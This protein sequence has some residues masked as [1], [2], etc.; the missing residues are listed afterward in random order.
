SLEDLIYRSLNPGKEPPARDPRLETIIMLAILKNI[1]VAEGQTF[2]QALDAQLDAAH[3]V[4][5]WI[6]S[7]KLNPNALLN[8]SRQR[9]AIVRALARAGETVP[10]QDAAEYTKGFL[11]SFGMD[12]AATA[13]D[14]LGAIGDMETA[15]RFLTERADVNL[16]T[17]IRNLPE[18]TRDLR[19]LLGYPRTEPDET[20]EMLFMG[21]LMATAREARENGTDFGAT[22]T[23]K[24]DALGRARSY[25]TNIRNPEDR[26][27][28][29]RSLR[30]SMDDR[31]AIFG[32]F[33]KALGEKM[34]GLAYDSRHP[35]ANAISFLVYFA[36]HGRGIRDVRL[37]IAKVGRVREMVAKAS[38]AELQRIAGVPAI[39]QDLARL[40]GRTF[41]GDEFSVIL[42]F[43]VNVPQEMRDAGKIAAMVE[44]AAAK[45]AK[46][47]PDE[48]QSVSAFYEDLLKLLEPAADERRVNDFVLSAVFA[49]F[50]GAA[51]EGAQIGDA[52]KELQLAQGFLRAVQ[53]HTKTYDGQTYTGAELIQRHLP[54]MLTK[55]LGLRPGQKLDINDYTSFVSGWLVSQAKSGRSVEEILGD[56]NTSGILNAT[57]ELINQAHA[58]GSLTSLRSHFR[59]VLRNLGM[60]EKA[61]D[62]MQLLSVVMGS[63][64]SLAEKGKGYS[65]LQRFNTSL[66][67]AVRRIRNEGVSSDEL[68]EGM[69]RLAQLIRNLGIPVR[70]DE[71]LT[72]MLGH[73]V[74]VGSEKRGSIRGSLRDI[75]G[76]QRVLDEYGAEKSKKLAEEDYRKQ[77]KGRNPPEDEKL[78][79]WLG[80]LMAMS[81][82]S[83]DWVDAATRSDAR[84]AELLRDP[85]VKDLILRASFRLWEALHQR[86]FRPAGSSDEA[87][88]RQDWYQE[89]LTKLQK[90]REIRGFV[91]AVAQAAAAEEDGV[92]AWADKMLRIA[93]ILID[94]AQDAAGQTMRE[95]ALAEAEKFMKA[96]LGDKAPRI[97]NETILESSKSQGALMGW[98]GLVVDRMLSRGTQWAETVAEID[99]LVTDY[100]KP[101]NKSRYDAAATQLMRLEE[102]VRIYLNPALSN[103]QR[104]A[105]AR[106]VD[107]RRLN[108]AQSRD[109]GRMIAVLFSL[110]DKGQSPEEAIV[111]YRE[112]ED[113]VEPKDDA[114]ELRDL[115]LR[116][117]KIRE[118]I[119]AILDPGLDEAE[120]AE[121]LKKADAR[122]LNLRRGKDLGMVLS[123][124]E[125]M[126]E[127]DRALDE[128]EVIIKGQEALLTDPAK[129]R[130]FLELAGRFYRL[131]WILRHGE[132]QAPPAQLDLN[133]REQFAYLISLIES[134]IE[135]HRDV[136]ELEDVLKAYE[137]IARDPAR[138][139]VF[140]D[141]GTRFMRVNGKMLVRMDKN[142]TPEELKARLEALDRQELNFAR[143][144]DF[145]FFLSVMELAVT[146]G[147]A[148]SDADFFIRGL[149]DAVGNEDLFTALC[150]ESDQI[151]KAARLLRVQMDEKLTPAEKEALR[152]G[153]NSHE[154]DLRVAKDRGFFLSWLEA[155]LVAGRRL[156]PGG[157]TD[158]IWAATEG[159]GPLVIETMGT[160]GIWPKLSDLYQAMM[161]GKVSLDQTEGQNWLIGMCTA[162]AS[163]RTQNPN[164]TKEQVMTCLDNAAEIAPMFIGRKDP[165]NPSFEGSRV[166][167]IYREMTG[168][169]FDGSR[170]QM[171]GW[172][173]GE[174]GFL[175][176]LFGQESLP[177]REKELW[178]GLN[179]AQR[180]REM[181][182]I[183]DVAIAL[184]RSGSVT[185]AGQFIGLDDFLPDFQPGNP[186][187][188]DLGFVKSIAL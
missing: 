44:N 142:L 34:P 173:H 14:V 132:E 134:S 130:K 68:I 176:G 187:G 72:Y 105:G 21:N 65:E 74:A 152:S 166:A 111:H 76:A 3:T 1:K 83:G 29:C 138:L 49:F 28:F 69:N 159:F 139:A 185:G 60:S 179:N 7:G 20:D 168:K 24:L 30:Q 50:M 10:E 27:A 78:A 13:D 55:L 4:N 144:E 140:K 93:D 146:R 133:N 165:N 94:P 135:K 59:F 91:S 118:K 17:R 48:V 157:R 169:E 181:H 119:R 162:V 87:A 154:F 150:G 56:D 97:T 12:P 109:M 89:F 79:V 167:Y 22:L 39:Y 104:E 147:W 145:A 37:E 158:R 125:M 54:D 163:A 161:V 31:A 143:N 99:A 102:K 172:L 170:S 95:V 42:S 116:A 38:P 70:E 103:A 9:D 84:L 171:M 90:D 40:T 25:I 67:R 51:R 98:L 81:R 85:E 2:E 75:K 108:L 26:E 53:G 110:H 123:I 52:F 23:A 178:E 149:E 64:S 63:F 86:D 113:L 61:D 46:L 114:M 155:R 124:L 82:D 41:K 136:G 92:D 129:I 112:M 126:V 141:L 156:V 127:N 151:M 182:L 148:D 16:K 160:A 121:A 115:S 58:D 32:T 96:F 88:I 19:E 57:H 107:G 184:K 153:I 36:E 188:Q 183:Y 100:Q 43:L 120:K 80:W 106:Q 175:A 174:I 122:R 66:G 18:R 6:E 8:I 180:V 117:L 77:H 35:A 5:G 71:E 101:E 128:V 15:A 45:I 186:D 73:L 177:K 11:M 131:E 62:P 33:Q 137:A 164:L 47:S